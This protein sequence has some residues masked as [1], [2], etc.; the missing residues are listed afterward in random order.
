MD[1]IMRNTV[2]NSF[3]S[4]ID[5]TF[6]NK[7]EIRKFLHGHERKKLCLENLF[8]EI[9]NIER[10]NITLLKA[11][12]LTTLGAEY[13]RIFCKAALQLEEE[14]KMHYLDKARKVAEY[15]AVQETMDMFNSEDNSQ[16]IE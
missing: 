8:R 15:K 6:I 2:E 16:V 1:F 7:P 4:F 13:G 12:H 9:E 5:S 14:D 11:D 10:T 3:N